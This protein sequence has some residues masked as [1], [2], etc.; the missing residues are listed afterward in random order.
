MRDCY[1]CA[2]ILW[3]ECRISTNMPYRVLSR[4]IARIKNCH[5]LIFFFPLVPLQIQECRY[6]DVHWGFM[7]LFPK[8]THLL[9]VVNYGQLVHVSFWCFLNFFLLIYS[10]VF[11]LI[12]SYSFSFL[13]W[14]SPRVVFF[15]SFEWEGRTKGRK[16]R[17]PKACPQFLTFLIGTLCP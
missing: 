6:V 17:K 12:Q 4:Y 14:I 9:H 13:V 11:V 15:R 16:F 8:P 7:C 2:H 1:C 10:H 5:L 3:L